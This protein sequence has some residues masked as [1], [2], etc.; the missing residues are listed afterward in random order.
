M[1]R[2][3]FTAIS[4][5]NR[6]MAGIMLAVM[7]LNAL[8]GLIHT[9][10]P[11]SGWPLLTTALHWSVMAELGLLSSAVAFALNGRLLM[12]TVVAL[13][14]FPTQAHIWL[15]RPQLWGWAG[16]HMFFV[17]GLVVVI[18]V[19]LHWMNIQ[20]HIKRS[21]AAEGHASVSRR[22]VHTTHHAA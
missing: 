21:V 4:V 9:L 3:T 14:I 10:E 20:R 16:W 6:Q 11:M 17:V 7:A 1:F 18:L 2:R 5:Q 19:R 12:G 13:T 22:L 8:L 15:V